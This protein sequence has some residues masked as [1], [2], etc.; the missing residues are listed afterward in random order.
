MKFFVD[1][2]NIEDIEKLIPTGFVDGVTTNP[3]LI[4]KQGTNMAETIKTIC[5]LIDGPV[6]AEVTAT[7]YEQMLKEGEYLASLAKN[8]AVKVPL[9]PDGLM[10]CSTLRGKQIMVNVT[11]CFSTS[12]ALLAAKAGASFISPFVGR[13]DDIGE[14][15]MDLIK[16]I[17]TM[18]KN[19]NFK[20]K[21]LVASIRNIQHVVDASLIGADIATLPPKIIYDLYKHD[22]TDKG[23]KAFLDDWAKTN[24]SILPK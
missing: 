23:L 6:S 13:L 4:A 18:Y 12:Q 19:Y 3:S 16:N 7:K 15:G 21:V 22:L 1:T 8:V 5:E 20:T 10:A 9:T 2:A 14:S 11:L 17:V 24:Q